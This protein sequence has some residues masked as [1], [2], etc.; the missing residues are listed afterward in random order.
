MSEPSVEGERR[1]STSEV[2]GGHPSDT[3]ARQ[4]GATEFWARIRDHKVLQ[5]AL[6]YLGASLAIAPAY[7]GKWG[8]FCRPVGANDLECR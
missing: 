2:A 8:E 3:P 4:I 6:A 5:W 7:A 1:A